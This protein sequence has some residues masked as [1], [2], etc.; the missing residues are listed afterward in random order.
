MK[1]IVVVCCGPHSEEH[2]AGLAKIAGTRAQ[3]AAVCDHDEAKAKAYAQQFGFERTYTDMHAM[4]DAE[5]PDGI[6]AITPWRQN[7]TIAAEL[8]KYRIPMIIEKPPG[9]T[10]DK[11][12]KL[13]DQVREHDVPHIV[14]FNRRFA[15]ALVELRKTF[16]P[17]MHVT[18]RMIRENRTEWDFVIGT[19]IHLLDAVFSLIG[20]P[21]HIV[22]HRV[23][24]GEVYHHH[25]AVTCERGQGTCILEPNASRIEETYTAGGRVADLC[26]A[27]APLGDR[28]GSHS[29]MSGFIDL[30]E[31][32][33]THGATMDDGVAVMVAAEM[34]ERN[35]SGPVPSFD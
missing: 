5:Q 21:R 19:A 4:I 27:D 26:A 2:G 24:A 3:L 11:A 28:Y 13:R 10:A 18:A 1:K 17:D 12:R 35:E 7:D 6:A 31:G 8:L 23:P 33:D 22:T 14:S 32:R 30:I 9:D 29:E 25:V 15:P 20:A 34:I 16:T